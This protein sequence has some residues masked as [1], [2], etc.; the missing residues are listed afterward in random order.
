MKLFF[1]GVSRVL[2]LSGVVALTVLLTSC[3][4]S[5]VEPVA[6]AESLTAATSVELFSES[7]EDGWGPFFRSGGLDCMISSDQQFAYDGTHSVNLQDNSGW[8]SSL[9]FADSAMV[10][11]QSQFSKLRIAFKLTFHDMEDGEKLH[12]KYF[13]GSRWQTKCTY[14]VGDIMKNDQMWHMGTEFRINNSGPIIFRFECDA[15]S[16]S[17]DVYLDYIRVIGK[18]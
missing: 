9:L 13:N 10:F 14:T 6:D 17:D 12:L 5:V 7:F 4:T 18:Y 11:D 3:T 2:L 16:N 1:K 15:S 8:G